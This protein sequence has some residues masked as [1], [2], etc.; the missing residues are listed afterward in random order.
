MNTIS[1]KKERLPIAGVLDRIWPHRSAFFHG[2]QRIMVVRPAPAQ[3]IS[4]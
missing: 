3:G 2:I 1:Q 4:A